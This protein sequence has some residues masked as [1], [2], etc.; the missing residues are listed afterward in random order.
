MTRVCPVG[1]EQQ[2][3]WRKC[4]GVSWVFSH[5]W[6]IACNAGNSVSYKICDLGQLWKIIPGE[7]AKG[8]VFLLTL[9]LYLLLNLR[10]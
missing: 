6:F 4:E 3:S 5:L 1:A 2:P 9:L 10:D 7:K 8:L